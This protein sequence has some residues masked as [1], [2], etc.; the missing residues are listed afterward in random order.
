MKLLLQ[1]LSDAAEISI[2]DKLVLKAF[3]SGGV[4]TVE[5]LEE[6]EGYRKAVE[7]SNTL[8]HIGGLSNVLTASTDA[9]GDAIWVNKD[10]VSGVSEINSLAT[11]MFDAS[12]AST[13]SIKLNVT[14]AG[15]QNAVIAKEGDFT[16]TVDSFEVGPNIVKID[17]GDGD[18]TAKFTV[19]VIFTVFGEGDTNDATY[20]VVSSA[21]AT[22]TNI[23]VTE[24]PTVN[25]T[26][27]GFIWLKA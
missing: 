1:R 27:T 24:T 16:Y 10:R 15:W 9:S 14:A 17:A 2:E 26:A 11:L 22:T 5:Y 3:A 7:V 6:I 4:V 19:G 21:F 8:T 23:T 18:L 20:T 13:Q 25:A 12:G